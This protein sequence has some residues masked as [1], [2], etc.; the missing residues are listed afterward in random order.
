MYILIRWERGLDTYGGHHIWRYRKLA[1]DTHVNEQTPTAFDRSTTNPQQRIIP[2]LDLIPRPAGRVT[3]KGDLP[4]F[5][6]ERR[7]GGMTSLFARQTSQIASGSSDDAMWYLIV[8][9]L[10]TSE[11]NQADRGIIYL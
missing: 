8:A 3:H 11:A 10:C 5:V 4:L 6:L 7:L 9:Q 1:S 2:A